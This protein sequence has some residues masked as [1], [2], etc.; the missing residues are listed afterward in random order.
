MLDE[1]GR[2]IRPS[3][4]AEWR[5]DPSTES[6]SYTELIAYGES[7]LVGIEAHRAWEAMIWALIARQPLMY[8]GLAGSA[9]SM[10]S[11][12]LGE[13]MEGA[14]QACVQMHPQASPEELLGAVS[15]R[16]LDHDLLIRAW[17]DAPASAHIL[18]IDEFEK[19][20]D[21]TQQ[22]LLSLLAERVIFDGGRE[23][24][25]PT[26]SL[27]ATSNEDIYDEAV[28][29]RFSLT[30]WSHRHT[31]SAFRRD[32]RALRPSHPSGRLT[33]QQIA[34]I[35]ESASRAVA[36]QDDPRHA[37]VWADV[38][39]ALDYCSDVMSPDGKTA[40]L[41]ERR[42]LQLIELMGAVAACHGR[43]YITRADAIVL[44]HAPATVA[45]QGLMVQWLTKELGIVRL[46]G[47]GRYY[48]TIEQSREE[49][50]NHALSTARSAV[51]RA[52][53]DDA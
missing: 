8:R 14:R 34:Q 52:L 13:V 9:K 26:E 49:A 41:S 33:S 20:S 7:R 5:S 43:N 4:G 44:H 21:A 24:A 35:R 2:D 3:R 53:G 46:A 32:F 1:Q 51:A 28:R 19:A 36:S 45:Q 38:D 17:Q 48:S 47:Y 11:R 40:G 39:R 30:V 50:L 37:S 6:I 18:M 10:L 15:L 16:G 23:F 31:P 12:M 42:V 27:I 25:M 29:D 22:S